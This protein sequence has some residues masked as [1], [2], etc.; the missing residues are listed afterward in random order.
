MLLAIDVGNTNVTFAVYDGANLHN[1]W[2]ATTTADRTADEYA[3]LLA[4]L[5]SAADLDTGDIDAAIIASVV[6]QALPQLRALCQ[7]FFGCEPGVV[8]ENLDL[9]LD[10]RI[11]RPADVGADRLVNALAA[12]QSYGGALII[13]DFGTA[14]TFDV[15]DA[16]GAYCG[17]IIAPGVNLS[18]EALHGAAAQLP[19]IAVTRPERVIGGGTIPAMQSGI[20]WG[21]LGLVE[22]LVERIKAE[23]GAAMTVIATGGLASQFAGGTDVIEH[24]DPDLTIRGLWEIHRRNSEPVP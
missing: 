5:M 13:V 22:G 1:Q 11:E 17:G 9:G 4:Q 20:Y 16:E 21:Y 23:Y 15:V 8:G 19:R 3:V 24:V 6:P 18:L 10:V 12:H 7:N 2:R 14:T